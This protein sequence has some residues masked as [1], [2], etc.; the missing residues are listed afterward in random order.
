MHQRLTQE[1]IE[2]PKSII[3]IKHLESVNEIISKRKYQVVFIT[4]RYSKNISLSYKFTQITPKDKNQNIY[5]THFFL[6]AN[7]IV[8]SKPDTRTV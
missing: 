6:E 8:T 1:E 3:L 5:E 4:H 2:R 7:M